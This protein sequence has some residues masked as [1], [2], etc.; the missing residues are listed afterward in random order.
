ME[1]KIEDLI[2]LDCGG[3]IEV[4]SRLGYAIAKCEKCSKIN[5]K[6]IG[7]S[8]VLNTCSNCEKT[9]TN[10]MKENL[11]YFQ[12][13][14]IILCAECFEIITNQRKETEVERLRRHNEFLGRELFG[15]IKDL[16][17]SQD[18][19]IRQKVDNIKLKIVEEFKE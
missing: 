11:D 12:I 1:Y 2:H 18:S 14:E 3:K 5:P 10:Y 15:L 7:E 9:I 4:S 17:I 8:I 6:S 13:E 19:L 16:E